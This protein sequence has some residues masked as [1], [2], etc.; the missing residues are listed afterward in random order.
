MVL[1]TLYKIKA[2]LLHNNKSVVV[3]HGTTDAKKYWSGYKSNP[4]V[5]EQWVV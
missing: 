3:V 4:I 1:M 2:S 5:W